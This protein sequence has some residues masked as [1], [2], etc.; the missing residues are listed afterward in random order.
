M[1]P[2]VKTK[3]L[4]EENGRY[5]IIGKLKLE[6][7]SLGLI[8]VSIPTVSPLIFDGELSVSCA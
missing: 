7:E 6:V 5:R 3:T 2:S 1:A 4:Q 8:S